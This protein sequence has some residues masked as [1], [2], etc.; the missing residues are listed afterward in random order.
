MTPTRYQPWSL[1]DQMRKE[2]ERH[3]AEGSSVATSDWVPAV[4]IKEEQDRF[5]I[6][7]D[8][9]GVDPKDIE[10]H[11]E[12]GMITIKGEK[13]SEK[14]EEKEGYKRVERSFGSF[15]RRFS[16]PDTADPDKI[17][18]KSRHGVLEVTIPKHQKV[19]ARKIS[20]ES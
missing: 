12:N 13:E 4:D 10:V 11:M 15:Y 17:S 16:L 5:V 20:V 6:L 3:N 2:L 8:I 14:K 9:P 18:A 19:Q 7:A 1:L